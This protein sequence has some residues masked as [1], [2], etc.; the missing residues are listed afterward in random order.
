MI[1]SKPIYEAHAKGRRFYT[2]R[3]FERRIRQRLYAEKKMTKKQVDRVVELYYGKKFAEFLDDEGFYKRQTKIWRI[4]K[5]FKMRY[6][7]K[8]L[9]KL[10]ERSGLFFIVKDDQ[11]EIN[12]IKSSATFMLKGGQLSLVKMENGF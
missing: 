10:A 6:V 2:N 8:D 11:G 3:G 1:I 12:A 7:V 9:F 5:Q 4:G